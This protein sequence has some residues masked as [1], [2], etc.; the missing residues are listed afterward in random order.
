MKT[1]LLQEI[2]KRIPKKQEKYIKNI[3]S[4]RRTHIFPICGSKQKIYVSHE[5][6]QS[7]EKCKK[8]IFSTPLHQ[9]DIDGFKSDL[10]LLLYNQL[11]PMVINFTCDFSLV[12]IPPR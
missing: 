6:F 7:L 3:T 8:K 1:K 10:H 5:R 4:E 2:H 9:T 11:E 12:C